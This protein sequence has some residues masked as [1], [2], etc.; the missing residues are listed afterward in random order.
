MAKVFTDRR[1]AGRQLAALLVSSTRLDPVILGIPRGGVPVADEVAKALHAWLDVIVVRKLGVPSSPELAMG[2][3]G[4]GSVRELD[5][6]ILAL[7]AVTDSQL[8]EVENRELN[9]LDDRVRR[10]RGTHPRLE[11]R[12][13]NIIVVDDGIA[14]GSTMRAAC[15]AARARGAAHIIAAAPVAPADLRHGVVGADEIVCVEFPRAFWAV[16]AHYRD[17]EATSDKEVDQI[18]AA[19]PGETPG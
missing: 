14:T 13:R 19:I 3:I 7:A 11:L 1:D 15:T 5:P 10:L 4:E 6:E 16:G 2:A 9:V 12:G 18:L 8:S 17:F